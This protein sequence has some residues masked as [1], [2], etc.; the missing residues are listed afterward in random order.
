M[1]A[2]AKVRVTLEIDTKSEWNDDTKV[3]QIKKQA[4]DIAMTVLTK[5]A[6][7]S[8]YRI[9]VSGEVKVKVITFDV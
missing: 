6:N 8:N 7:D 1:S 4:T 2:I 3:L 9:K 5:L